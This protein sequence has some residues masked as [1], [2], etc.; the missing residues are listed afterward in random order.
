[1]KSFKNSEEL[2]R[3]ILIIGFILIALFSLFFSACDVLA[4][5][6]KKILIMQHQTLPVFRDIKFGY[7]NSLEP[8]KYSITQF[9]AQNDLNALDKYID[10]ITT[11]KQFD[12]IIS[13]GS[14]TTQRLLAKEKKVPVLISGLASPEYS[15]I[16]KN[17]S[18]SGSNFSGVE[19][20]N[21]TYNG[22][23]YL[24]NIL[25]FTKIGM[26]YI[27]GE[28]SHEGT[29]KE[30]KALA[31]VKGFQVFSYGIINRSE[32]QIKFPDVVMKKVISDALAKVV[33]YVDTFYV[34]LSKTF[35]DNYDVFN[36]NFI[37]NKIMSIGDKS[38]LELGLCIGI[39]SDYFKRGEELAC[40]T[41]QILE[42][43]V[44]PKDLQMNMIPKFSIEYN[45]EA[46]KKIEYNPSA[47]FLLNVMQVQTNLE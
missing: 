15:G 1:M 31:E 9:N 21:Q 37:K 47:R 18:S 41:N 45:L 35:I 3:D 44:N 14:I 2:L 16:I 6:Q 7:M 27:I 32:K 28:P 4:A 17:W 29:L 10:K 12:L 11:Q 36:D 30:I 34:N 24:Y 42:N 40:Y 33:P 13:I 20:K 46:A 23:S 43:N 25:P 8:N 39:T 5:S 38:Y 19:I 22:L 26:I